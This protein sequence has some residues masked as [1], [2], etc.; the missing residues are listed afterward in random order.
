[1]A[2]GIVLSMARGSLEFLEDGAWNKRF[3]P[4]WAGVSGITAATLARQGFVGAKRAYD[5]RF[6][7][8]ASH[9]QSH[10]DPQSALALTTGSRR[11]W[12]SR[13]RGEALP[14]LPLRACLPPMPP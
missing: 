12:Q 1:M 13:S 5:G 4:G 7:L 6:G 2:Q 10:F 14:R 3:H 11:S 8:Y 9:L